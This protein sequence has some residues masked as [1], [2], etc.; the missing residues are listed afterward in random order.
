[1]LT[2]LQHRYLKKSKEVFD[3]LSVAWSLLQDR[4][5]FSIFFFLISML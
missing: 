1:M 3:K 2:T 4:K 5:W